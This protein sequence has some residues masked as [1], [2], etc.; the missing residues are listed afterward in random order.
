M[1]NNRVV[2]CAGCMDRFESTKTQMYRR[3]RSCGSEKCVEVIDQKVAKANYKKQ[4]KKIENGKFRHG[5][6]LVLK[7][8]VY[9]RD[10]NSCKLCLNDIAQYGRQVHHIVPVSE[11]GSDDLT[12]LVLLCKQCHTTVHKEGHEDYYGKFRTYIENLEKVS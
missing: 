6:S 3:K 5:V 9:T 11:N 4:Q 7:Q 1:G 2:I 8:E 12:N 10:G